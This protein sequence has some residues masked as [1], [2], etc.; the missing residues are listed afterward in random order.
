MFLCEFIRSESFTDNYKYQ[1][2][3]LYR[4]HA[5]TCAYTHMLA[6][7]VTEAKESYIA[8]KEDHSKET[9]DAVNIRLWSVY[10]LVSSQHYIPLLLTACIVQAIPAFSFKAHVV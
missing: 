4:S 10:L 7:K 8:R 9:L 1:H 5:A 2:V 6:W 3:V